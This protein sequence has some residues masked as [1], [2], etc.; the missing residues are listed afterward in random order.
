MIVELV[1]VVFDH[2]VGPPET[3]ALQIRH[4][5]TT[6]AGAD[7][8]AYALVPAK[9]QR[10][11]VQAE[12]GFPDLAGAGL[13]TGSVL[14]VRA[15]ATGSK[16]LGHIREQDVVVPAAGQTATVQFELSAPT[17][18]AEGV[19][20]YSVTWEWQFK[21]AP[22]SPWIAFGTRSATIY[23]TLDRPTAPWT[24]AAD[25]ASQRRW[26]WV[27]MLDLACPWAAGVTLS[28]GKAAAVKRIA[29]M[30]ERALLR[31]GDRGKLVYKTGSP[32]YVRGEDLT[33][34]LTGFLDD[35][36]GP[37]QGLGIYCTECAA[38]VVIA[39]NCL[40]A[41][42]TL[43]H[44]DGG[45]V[46]LQLNTCE[47]IGG[48]RF[49]ASFSTHDIAIQETSSRMR[50]FDAT[51][52]LDLDLHKH[53]ER[54]GLAQGREIGKRDATN[55][56]TSRKYLHRL[57]EADSERQWEELTMCRR[58]VP[59]LDET[60]GAPDP[61][62]TQRFLAIRQRIEVAAPPGAPLF[63]APRQIQPLVVDGFR[64]YNRIDSPARLAALP[65]LV[66]ASTEFSYVAAE[67]PGPPA[68]G[69][70]RRIVPR[71][72]R[73]A[74]AWSPTPA[75]ARDALAWLLTRDNT[76]MSVFPKGAAERVGDVALT[77]SRG[78]IVY[79]VRGNVLAQI[80]PV[81]DRRAPVERVARA[82]DRAIQI[83]WSNLAPKPDRPPAP[84][85]TKGK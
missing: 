27:R 71:Q 60:L 10:L 84:S 48:K 77:T 26:P 53:V 1:R 82:M 24:Q 13:G 64:L 14:R 55:R 78:A 43:L 69:K 45:P 74:V 42:L 67:L 34:Q 23:V 28:K 21:L 18:Q 15:R 39:A 63:P 30:T 66:S 3:R 76:P 81:G 41:D 51:L 57:L 83:Q 5:R 2:A 29:A 32:S 80:M 20:K 75:A 56:A 61:C 22:A 59:G 52:K 6:P 12:L 46:N 73:I 40:G 62:D 16:V 37:K 47:L 31:L 17:L 7:V 50:V 19:G 33:F 70:L 58:A 79:M 68:R 4:D 35:L 72:F 44:L 9:G 36:Q 65:R 25:L 49:T 11:T 54:F 8:A 85:T 38:A